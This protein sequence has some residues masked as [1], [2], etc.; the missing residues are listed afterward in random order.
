MQE[1]TDYNEATHT[2]LRNEL[3]LSEIFKF[4]GTKTLLC[5]SSVN[6]LWK[7]QARTY[8]RDHRKCTILIQ[9]NSASSAG[10]HRQMIRKLNGTIGRM[11]I[12]PFNS[13]KLIVKPYAHGPDTRLRSSRNAENQSESLARVKT[14][15]ETLLSK[16]HVNHLSI[17]WDPGVP[18][19]PAT[20]L[21][22]LL[23]T[24]ER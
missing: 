19:C 17:Y 12:V 10:N 21:I 1:E 13:V 20:A 15:W 16:I 18:G 22:Y 4:F 3:V 14:Q 2:A 6:K 5:C 11:G 8:I 9:L 23:L 24:G 7:N